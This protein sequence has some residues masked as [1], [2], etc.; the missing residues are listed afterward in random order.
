[1]DLS[2]GVSRSTPQSNDFGQALHKPHIFLYRQNMEAIR[3]FLS[4]LSDIHCEILYGE[5]GGDRTHNLRIKSPLLYQLSYI[6][7]TNNKD[8]TLLF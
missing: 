5:D 3:L 8:I 6:P 1:M 4:A 2:V 7:I